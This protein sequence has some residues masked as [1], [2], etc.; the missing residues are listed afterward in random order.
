MVK[1]TV[2]ACVSAY[3]DYSG[4]GRK[5]IYHSRYKYADRLKHHEDVV[6]SLAAGKKGGV[7]VFT[8]QVAEMSLDI[9]VDLLVTDIAPVS[10]LIQRLGRLNR[11]GLEKAKPFIVVGAPALVY[12]EGDLKAAWAW[13]ER[14]KG[15]VSQRDL[16]AA[17]G[18]DEAEVLTP[19]CHIF[20]SEP[21]DTVPTQFRSNDTPTIS[22]VLEHDAAKMKHMVW[23]D[24]ARARTNC[25]I[26]MV[27]A[28]KVKEILKLLPKEGYLPIVGTDI[29]YSEETGAEWA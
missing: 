9:S 22:V 15:E 18:C 20:E 7:V 10:S 4:P 23:C 27:L 16:Q 29:I 12:S 2:K 21:S 8:T 24:R 5:I 14:L 13:V 25:S 11:H 1:N 17:V 28:D 6:S 26:P 3:R 19:R